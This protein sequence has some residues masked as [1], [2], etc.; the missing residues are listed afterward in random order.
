MFQLKSR[1]LVQPK[2][3]TTCH[4]DNSLDYG[5]NV[6]RQYALL[7]QPC[8]IILVL[9]TQV[10][11]YNSNYN[12]LFICPKCMH[13]I[14][15]QTLYLKQSLSMNSIMTMATYYFSSSR[16]NGI[17]ATYC[18]HREGGGG[19]MDLKEVPAHALALYR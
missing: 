17:S 1:K 9:L 6:Q 12:A 13:E 15:R 14:L 5:E 11:W 10:R 4:V 8:C 2:N 7:T 19:V 16:T 3:P 18:T